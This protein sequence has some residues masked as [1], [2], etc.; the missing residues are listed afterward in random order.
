MTT[1]AVPI[2]H[3][4]PLPRDVVEKFGQENGSDGEGKSRA[5]SNT[6]TSDSDGSD[7]ITDSESDGRSNGAMTITETINGE[8]V[9]Y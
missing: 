9:L 8:Y 6:S 1:A 5:D 2:L 7:F 3:Y 4:I